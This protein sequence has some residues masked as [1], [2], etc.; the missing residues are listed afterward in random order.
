MIVYTLPNCTACDYT[1]KKLDKMG[2]KYVVREFDD[3]A[4]ALAREKGYSSAP[5][6]VVGDVSWGGLRVNLIEKYAVV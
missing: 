2:A 5:L 1:K 4:M 6:V 3:A